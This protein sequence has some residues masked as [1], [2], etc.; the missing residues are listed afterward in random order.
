MIAVQVANLR[1]GPFGQAL[2]YFNVVVGN[3][4][5]GEFTGGLVLKDFVLKKK[6]DGSS[7]YWSPPA[8]QRLKNG[9][10]QKDAKGFAIWDDYV[11]LFA[12]DSGA[13]KL[14]HALRT[15]ILDQ[16]V[17]LYEAAS[18]SNTGRG[19]KPAAKAARPAPQEDLADD[20]PF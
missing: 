16:A 20:L 3:K 14:A 2:A 12:E 5:D 19:S 13:T 15:S 1:P 11:S 10:P 17:Q 7:Y 9:Q 6:K 4:E 18:G 8:K